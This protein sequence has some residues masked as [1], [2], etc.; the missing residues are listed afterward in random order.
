M[1]TSECE[2]CQQKFS[3]TVIEEYRHW[4]LQ[5]FTDQNYLGRSLVKLKRH[6]VDLTDLRPEERKEFFEKVLPELEDVLDQVFGPD[7]Y[8]QATLGNDCRHFHFHVIP[9]YSSERNF[10]GERFVDEN[11]NS[12]YKDTAENDTSKEVF[13]SIKNRLKQEIQK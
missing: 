13:N 7:L 12:H 1:K 3:D 9:R 8:N 4:E 2:F 6:A 10:A 5:L 11:W